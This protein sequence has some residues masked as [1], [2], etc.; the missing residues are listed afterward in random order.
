MIGVIVAAKEENIIFIKVNGKISKQESF[1]PVFMGK[2]S[3]ISCSIIHQ[4]SHDMVTNIEN[5]M[6]LKRSV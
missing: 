3:M 2:V 6:E 4:N 1:C 5:V